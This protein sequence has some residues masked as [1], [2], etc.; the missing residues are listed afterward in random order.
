MSIRPA[1]GSI[2]LWSCLAAQAPT[3]SAQLPPKP[4]PLEISADFPFESRFVEVLD[5][6]MHYIEVGEGPAVVFLHGNPTSSYLWRNVIPHLAD[7]GRCIAV[8]LIGMGKSE[9]PDID[10]RY[11]DHR[12]YLDVFLDKMQLGDDVTLVIHDWGSVLGFD[13]ASRHEDRVAGVAFMEALVPP[14]FPMPSI[15]QM[16]GPGGLFAAFRDP[17]QGQQL[18][19][20]QN[21]FVE[22]VLPGA[23]V[24]DLTEAEREAYRAPYV[25]PASRKPTLLWPRELPIGGDPVDTTRVVGAIGRWMLE[26]ET[27]MLHLWATPGA[28]NGE[29]VAT[30]FSQNLKNIQSTFLGPGLHF[31]QED[32]PELIGRAVA[33]WRRRLLATRDE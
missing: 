21:V 24:R 19:I 32:H 9:K 30:F 26:T 23:I 33:D 1:L 15:D 14:A 12:K 5:S 22:Q 8:D 13:W 16:G 4:G 17:V 10:Y 2:C 18:I 20:E 29:A 11:V 25:E 27:P 3:T 7:S 28:L 31:V 6:K